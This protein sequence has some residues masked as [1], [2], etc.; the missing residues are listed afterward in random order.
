MF[1]RIVVGVAAFLLFGSAV[2]LGVAIAA[3]GSP[4]PVPTGRC[5][6][7]AL[8][9][10]A[11]GVIGAAR[12]AL[13]EAARDYRGLRTAGRAALALPQRRRL[14][15]SLSPRQPECHGAR[16]NTPAT[17]IAPCRRADHW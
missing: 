3:P 15:V 10:P 1:R 4:G 16:P 12:R 6:T 14:A 17:V 2:S 5:P 8:G 9:L 11:D 7:A 13:A